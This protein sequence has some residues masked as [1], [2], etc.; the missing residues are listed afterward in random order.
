M[1]KNEV[2]EESF[3]ELLEKSSMDTGFYEPGQA[4]ETEIVAI[5]G[6]S[7]FLQMNGKSEGVMD[8]EELTD[9][10]G[11]LTV[12]EG[13]TIK[14]FFLKSQNGEMRFTT[15]ISSNEAGQAIL[16]EAYEKGIPV[17]GVVDKEIKG[18]FQVKVG[19]SRA[20]CPFSQM[21]DRRVEDAADWIGRHLSFKITEH[22]ERGRNIIV[23]HRAILEEEK[24]Q[25]KEELTKTLEVGMTV[26]ATVKSLRDFG[27]F[28]D[29]SGIQALLPISEISHARVDDIETVLTVGQE[30]EVQILRLDWKNDRISVSMKA[31]LGDPWD[32]AASQYREGSIHTGKIARITDFGAFVTLEPG[33][34]G[35]VHVSE[36][37]TEERNVRPKDVFKK[38]D[39]IKVRILSVD[40]GAKRISLKHI[41]EG[42]EENDFSSYMEPESTTYNPF[43]ALL[44]DK[45]KK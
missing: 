7:I 15:R 40:T 28:V 29:L 9:K 39:E 44:K 26:Q 33:M 5:A 14:V 8:A 43:A 25:K 18:G 36:I 23:S 42:D 34:D 37:S 12:K 3:A 1:S 35:L 21:G 6:D 30:I 16:Q 31:L 22:S 41:G 38:G 10:E 2:R 17:E 19:E 32:D 20:F 13:D 24:A 27:A 45:V 11:N 4:V